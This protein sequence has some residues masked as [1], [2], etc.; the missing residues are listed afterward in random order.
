MKGDPQVI[1]HLNSI[2]TSKLTAINQYFLQSR[3]L[4]N[5]GLLNLADHLQGEARSKMQQADRLIERILFLEGMPNLQDLERIDAGDDAPAMIS[6]DLSSEESG[7]NTALEGVRY[8][9]EVRDYVS[10]ELLTG[11]LN[12]TESHIDWLTQQVRLIDGVGA[13]N[14]KQEQM[15]G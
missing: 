14:Y 4:K 15:F 13:E 12:E 2:L 3:M 6:L 9:E 11:I 7:R 10:R 1:R 8:C 5:I